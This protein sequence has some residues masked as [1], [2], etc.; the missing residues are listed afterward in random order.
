MSFRVLVCGG[1][2]YGDV[3]TL[4]RAL[5]K[6]NGKRGI[7]CVISGAASGA[8]RLAALW[9]KDRG[10]D[11]LEFP[12]DWVKHGKAAGPMRNQQM[13]DEGK[14]DGVVAFPGGRGT[15]DMTSRAKLAGIVVWE[16]MS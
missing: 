16:P 12:A 15:L 8:D 1:R 14:P 6:L 3:E 13:L 2:D 11:L 9:A 10:I 7:S 5:D 4:R